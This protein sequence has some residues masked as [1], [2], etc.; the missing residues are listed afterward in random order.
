MSGALHNMNRL[1]QGGAQGE[2]NLSVNLAGGNGASQVGA[3]NTET[4]GDDGS[5]SMGFIIGVIGAVVV[6]GILIV[7]LFMRK[8]ERKAKS[9]A[10]VV[11]GKMSTNNAGNYI[12]ELTKQGKI[13]GSRPSSPYLVC[14]ILYN[15]RRLHIYQKNYKT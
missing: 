4:A 3:S 7:A 11:A 1:L 15:F 6:G 13:L 12:F 5:S 8:K 2:F 9:D 10:P 14:S